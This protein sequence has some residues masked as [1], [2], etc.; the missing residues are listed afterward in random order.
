M[1]TGEEPERLPCRTCGELAALGARQCPHCFSSLLVDVTLSARVADGRLRYRVARA[2]HALPEAPSLGEIQSSLAGSP[3]AAVRGVTR[4]FAHAALDVLSRNGLKGSMEE[5]VA[6]SG[7]GR[8]LSLGGILKGAALVFLL[9]VGYTAW[10]QLLSKPSPSPA[11]SAEPAKAARPAAR[12]GAS[13][14][15]PRELAQRALPATV[16]LRCRD[17]VG[18][19]FF[20]DPE[21][22][23][24]NAHVLCPPGESLQVGLSDDRTLTG[25]VERA[26][27]DLDLALVHVSGADA[28]AL[29]LG[30]VGD[31]AVG[32][33][34]MIVGSPVGLDFTVQEGSIS[35]LQRAAFGVAYLQLDA[36]ISPGN[37][38]G[39]VVDSQGRVVGI[40]SM[41]LVGEGVEGIGLAIPINYVY[42]LETAFVA[43]P[44]PAAGG[45]QAFHR[46]VAQAQEQRESGSEPGP[47]RTDERGGGAGQGS[48]LDDRPLLVAGYVDQYRRL[49]VRILRATEVSPGFE[50]IT[51][52]LWSGT[53]AF[54]TIKGDVKDWKPA[55]PAMPHSG[56]DARS[57]SVLQ[58]IAPGRTFFVG[59]SPLRWDLCDRTKMR[60]GVE[61]ELEGANPIANRLLLR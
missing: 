27:D 29:P 5:P 60:S 1:T 41:K 30:D 49:V 57:A 11:G 34:V 3:P 36:K 47:L 42:D 23:I 9:L 15:S 14:L 16:S 2:L 46:M 32:D 19:G 43:P 55:D 22:V 48:V 53:D 61:L 25:L 26:N 17:S 31:V 39:P 6:P 12:A 54:C 20:I 59:E 44:T 58:R 51:V 38:G 8:G 35:S 4:A 13:P 28:R 18:S 52:T 33:R 50:E 7:E 56:L 10:H 21:R 37:S 45:S 24:T 40:V